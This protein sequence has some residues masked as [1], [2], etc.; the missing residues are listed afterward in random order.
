MNPYQESHHR[1]RIAQ[2]FLEEARQDV[3]LG[4]WRSAVD[5]CQMATEH[6]AK[7][8]LALIAP[9]GRT[10]NP[11]RQLRQAL[12]EGYLST[13]AEQVRALA[14]R[15][16]QLGPDIHMQTDYGDEQAGLTPWDLFDEAEARRCLNIAEE[17]CTFAQTIIQE[18]T[19]E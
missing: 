12:A 17:A 8:V 3:A 19:R 15:A 18:I 4:R 6:A 11:G 9:V 14:E 16:E 5:N 13:H 1:M 10:H 7:A 2:G